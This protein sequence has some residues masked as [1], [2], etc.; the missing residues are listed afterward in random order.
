MPCL[1]AQEDASAQQDR[2]ASSPLVHPAPVVETPLA[3][4]ATVM[5][6]V[7]AEMVPQV[8][9]PSAGLAAL[10]AEGTGQEVPL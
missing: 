1:A 2:H 6:P 4:E 3:D 7:R 5:G 10:A 8:C 9:P